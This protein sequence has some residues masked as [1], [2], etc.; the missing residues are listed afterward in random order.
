M[1]KSAEPV[2]QTNYR[3]PDGE[4]S[5]RIGLYSFMRL[6]FWP[7]CGL[8]FD[9][10]LWPFDLKNDRDQCLLWPWR[11][12]PLP[13]KLS[14]IT[15]LPGCCVWFGHRRAHAHTHTRTAV[16][17]TTRKHVSTTY[18]SYKKPL[19]IRSPKNSSKSVKFVRLMEVWAW[20]IG[21]GFVEHVG[22]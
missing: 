7:L 22:F 19:N 6:P 2:K 4:P 3:Q 12:N 15:S 10:H 17:Q 13:S 5:I 20:W 8:L 11:L 14:P 16:G 9:L 18:R 21:K 1:W